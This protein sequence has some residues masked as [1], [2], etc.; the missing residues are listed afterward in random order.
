MI[1]HLGN[2]RSSYFTFSDV[3]QDKTFAQSPN[4]AAKVSHFVSASAKFIRV[5]FF[6]AK[7]TITNAAA[8]FWIT[9]EFCDFG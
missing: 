5:T 4:N 6:H 7:L 8:A 2:V 1:G 3:L 9:T